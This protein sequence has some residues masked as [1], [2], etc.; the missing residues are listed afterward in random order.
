MRSSGTS[1]AYGAPAASVDA[2]GPVAAHDTEV[3]WQVTATGWVYVLHD[4]ERAGSTVITVAVADI[5][6]TTAELTTRGI[7]VGPI[8]PEG[9]AGRKA[10]V[11]DPDGNTIAIIE[12]AATA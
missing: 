3:M 7:A 2:P 1:A 12:V 6:R 4:P 8:A 10:L 5:E 11:R 9:D